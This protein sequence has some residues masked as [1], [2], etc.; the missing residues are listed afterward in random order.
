MNHFTTLFWDVDGT[1]LDFLYSQHYALRKCFHS[2][3]HGITEEMMQRYSAINDAYWKRLELGEISKNELLS[4]RFLT[5]FEEYGIRDIDVSAFLAEYQEALGS[6][7]R[8]LDDSLTVCKSLQGHIRQYVVTNGVASTQLNKLKISGL[9][10]TM[11]GIFISESLGA[12]KPHREFFER[13]FASLASEGG[14]TDPQ[15]MLI[16]GDSLSSDIKGGIQAGIAACWYRPE[17]ILEGNPQLQEQYGQ[18]QPDYEISD[19][20]QIYEVLDLQDLSCGS[21][22]KNI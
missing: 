8:Y 20:H 21:C 7:Y 17:G 10:G 12:P 22:R 13:C 16:V 15:N 2:A 18:Y 1:L 5:L 19:L 11:D 14:E 4:G 6:V 3:G 9:A